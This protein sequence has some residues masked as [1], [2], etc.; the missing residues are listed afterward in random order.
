M[1]YTVISVEDNVKT[2]Y[3]FG[4]VEMRVNCFDRHCIGSIRVNASYKSPVII[5]QSTRIA[6]RCNYL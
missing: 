6:T 3:I 4:R 1:N 2:W 5:A